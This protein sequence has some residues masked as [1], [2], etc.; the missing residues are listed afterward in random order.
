MKG[1]IKSFIIGALLLLAACTPTP[2][3]S[4]PLE[5][6]QFVVCGELDF[7]FD[8]EEMA[9]ENGWICVDSCPNNYDA[10]HTQVGPL[11]CIPHYGVEEINGWRTCIRSST[12]CDCV[13]AYETTSGESVDDA[14]FRCVP[15]QY[16]YRQLFYGGQTRLDEYGRASTMIA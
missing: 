1:I 11:M 8:V 2:P 5:D 4:S 10:Y 9:E 15:E 7:G 3:E 16:G 6:K 13:K 14:K 12:T